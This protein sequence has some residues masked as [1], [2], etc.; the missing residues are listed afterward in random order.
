MG[1]GKGR[2]GGNFALYIKIPKSIIIE[3]IRKKL[4]A[5]APDEYIKSGKIY[6]KVCKENILH[7]KSKEQGKLTSMWFKENFYLFLGGETQ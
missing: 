3:N 4:H 6:D 2:K 5:F 7:R 1:A